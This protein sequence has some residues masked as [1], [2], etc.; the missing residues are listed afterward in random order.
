MIVLPESNLLLVDKPTGITSFDVIRI[1]RK[2]LNIKKMGH[3]GTLD[4]LATGLLIIGINEGT[5]KLTALVGLNKTYRAEILLGVK[6]DSGDITGNSIEEKD[7]PDLSKDEVSAVIAHFVGQHHLKV[8]MYSAIKKDGKPL[9]TYA[10]ENKVVEVPI[11]TMEVLRAAVEKK[12]GNVLTVFFE[13][14]SGSYIRTLSEE[15]AKRLG[16]IGTIK[17]LRRLTVGHY[18]VKDAE[19][20][21]ATGYILR[22]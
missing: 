11:K 12:E 14:T 19:Q 6:T 16:T 22:K 15:L 20:I 2:E 7:V 3:A 10:R 1:L 4:P 8:P 21:D 17:N 5:K 13:V 18:S 9:Y